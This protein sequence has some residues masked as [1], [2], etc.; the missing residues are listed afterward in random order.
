MLI[1]DIT[2]EVRDANLERVGQI[3]E[4]NLVGLEVVARFNAVGAWRITLPAGDPMAD[5][6]R[7][8]GSGIIVTGS[9][10]VLLSGPTISA[11][12]VK[13]AENPE[14]EWEI[15]GADDTSV[16][17]HRVAYPTPAT[18]D[19]SLQSDFDV[20]TGPAESVMKAYVEANLGDD[21]PVSRQVTGLT[22]EADQA[23]GETVTGRARFQ[24]I[25]ELLTQLAITSGLGF[26]VAQNDGGLE[27][28]VYEP[29]DRSLSIR[30]DIDNNRLTK[31][32]YSYTAPQATRVIVA[33]QGTGADR[34]LVEVVSD[35]SEDAETLWAKRIELFKDSR[36]TSDLGELEQAGT[37]ILADKGYTVEAVSVTPTDDEVMSYPADWGLG[38][39]VSV[40][41]GDITVT[42]VVTEVAIVI[43][44]EGIKV[45][46]T[47]GDPATAT[48]DDVESQVIVKQSDQES[49][50]SNL[51]R[52]ELSGG[53]SGGGSSYNLD[54]GLP[55]TVYGG[56]DPID[57]GG[58]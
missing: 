11:K 22:V 16:L 53:G 46:A 18:D 3:T 45:G 43:T 1:Q 32:E 26:D 50:I 48:Q 23:R 12:S 10:G 37:E 39:K 49:R 33:G 54:A 2:V 52:N 28:K 21:A 8:P 24:P 40:V 15:T 36:N 51:E 35:A 19:L 13:T 47:V 44:E 42:Q 5:A 31:S 9:S 34:T 27:F 14:G 25:G 57:A 58:V 30:M 38:D 55:N 6:L 4:R 41:I 29:V 7:A 17:G 20:R 56:S